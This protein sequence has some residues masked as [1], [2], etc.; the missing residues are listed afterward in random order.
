MHTGCQVT[1][2]WVLSFHFL[3]FRLGLS[4]AYSFPKDFISRPSS[5]KKLESGFDYSEGPSEPSVR[6]GSSVLALDVWTGSLFVVG[7]H[8][9]I[10]SSNS[11]LYP[12]EASSSPVLFVTTVNVSPDIAKC[13]RGAGAKSPRLR[14][15]GLEEHIDGSPPL[16]RKLSQLLLYK[17]FSKH[18]LG[19]KQ[20]TKCFAY[21][22]SFNPHNYPMR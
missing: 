8:C 16:N 6:Q 3:E 21:I 11:G 17:Y 1:L 4:P 15:T 12:P 7:V 18:Y 22:F 9:S 20:R 14:I 13:P 19:A 2:C 5:R 10:F